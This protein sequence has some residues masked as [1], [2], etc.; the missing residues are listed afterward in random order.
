MIR[1][2]LLVLVT[3]AATASAGTGIYQRT[4]AFPD[5]PPGNWRYYHPN[6]GFGFFPTDATGA[7]EAGGFFFPKTFT[8]Y[9]ADT[10][11]NGAFSRGT[12]LS[13]NGTIRLDEVSFMPSYGNSVYVAHFH[14]GNT[15]GTFVNILGISLTGNEGGAILCAPVVQFSNGRAFLGRAI[16][17]PVNSTPLNWSYTWNPTGGKFQLGELTVTIGDATST[18]VLNRLSGSLD[19][20]LDS[21]GLYQPA[22]VEPD[23]S[24]YFVFF[25]DKLHYTA[26]VGPAPKISIKGPKSIRTST[27]SVT[28]RGTTDAVSAGNHV[29]AV[30]YRVI[31]DGK[32]GR[33]KTANGTANWNVTIT[34]PRGKSTV[35]FKAISDSGRHTERSRTVNRTP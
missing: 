5:G 33:Y 23:S 9:Y 15:N 30:R 17:L 3:V 31:H 16:K 19:Y 22:F 27:S 21:F 35:E 6:Q 2:A 7:G 24:S 11:L 25:I 18:L 20:T 28:I 12:P 14:K 10:V 8:A 34:V 1:R 32:T 13:A 29:T 4:E 26:R